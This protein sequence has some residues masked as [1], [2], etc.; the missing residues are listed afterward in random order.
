MSTLMPG[1]VRRLARAAAASAALI[2]ASACNRAAEQ[3]PKVPLNASTSGSASSGQAN[4]HE[5]LAPEARVALDSGNVA[6]R[7]GK[8]ERAL[9]QYRAA[10][11]AESKSAA[12]FYG[13]YMVAQ[14]LG[15]KGLADSVMAV[16]RERSGAGTALTDTSMAKMHNVAKA[17]PST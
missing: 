3:P 10:A 15:N 1:G 6:F 14:K 2:A 12:P 17:K 11:K 16:I 8:Y 5:Q 4:P 9:A 7:A 13:I